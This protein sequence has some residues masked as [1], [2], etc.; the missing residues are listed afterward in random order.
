MKMNTC[1]IM[2]YVYLHTVILCPCIINHAYL[3]C[4]C[5][6]SIC[7]CRCMYMYTCTHIHYVHLHKTINNYKI[8]YLMYSCTCSDHIEALGRATLPNLK[9]A[10]CHCCRVVHVYTCVACS[11]VYTQAVFLV[12]MHVQEHLHVHVHEH[13]HTQE[14]VMCTCM[15]IN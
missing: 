3:H 13:V 12:L 14:H 15:Y 7:T 10:T 1:I 8:S 4:T 2:Y 6:S 11:I 9:P 5:N